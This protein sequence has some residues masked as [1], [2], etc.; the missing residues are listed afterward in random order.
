VRHIFGDRGSATRVPEKQKSGEASPLFV[1]TRRESQSVDSHIQLPGVA[2]GPG[3]A[4]M[5]TV[6]PVSMVRSVR[7]GALSAYP[8]AEVFIKIRSCMM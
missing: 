5:H 6:L 4:P 8:L 3:F 7:R 1:S 2:G